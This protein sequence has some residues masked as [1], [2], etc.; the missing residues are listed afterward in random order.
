MAAGRLPGG[1][2][3]TDAAGGAHRT[4][5]TG[6]LTRIG[7]EI[8]CCRRPLAPGVCSKHGLRDRMTAVR[9]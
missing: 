2:A 3:G 6:T 8:E 7:A 5:V 9:P 1:P 4:F